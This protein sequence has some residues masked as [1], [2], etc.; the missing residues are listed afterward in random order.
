[1][2]SAIGSTCRVDGLV[3]GPSM[4]SGASTRT[5]RSVT[6][7]RLSRVITA[8][9]IGRGGPSIT[10]LDG[11][12]S[13]APTAGGRSA[14]PSPTTQSAST[15]GNPAPRAAREQPAIDGKILSTSLIQHPAPGQL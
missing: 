7:P 13:C 4:R 15:A 10:M 8:G 12:A 9:A 14:G 11:R 2:K 1:M 3:E 6:R 5:A